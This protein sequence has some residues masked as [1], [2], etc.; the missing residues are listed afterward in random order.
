VIAARPDGAM[1][2]AFRIAISIDQYGFGLLRGG[3]FVVRRALAFAVTQDVLP[4]PQLDRENTAGRRV[5][6]G[7]VNN[8]IHKRAVN[9]LTRHASRSVMGSNYQS[10]QVEGPA[11]IL[12][13]FPTELH[14]KPQVGVTLFSEGSAGWP[15]NVRRCLKN[16]L[17]T[18]P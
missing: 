10:P 16:D 4:Q 2:L 14:I 5:G 7:S 1:P 3:K 6:A 8:K 11:A 13:Q 9:P 18:T 15:H 12:I 17:R